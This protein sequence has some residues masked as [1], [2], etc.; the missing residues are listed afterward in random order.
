MRS[1]RLLVLSLVLC[2][3]NAPEPPESTGGTDVPAGPCGRGLIVVGTDNQSTNVSLLGLDGAVLSSS[4]ISSATKVTGLSTQLGNDVVPP[5]TPMTGDSIVL[6]DRYPASVLTW[7]DVKSA[8]VGGQLSIRA[9]SEA[10]PHD[11]LELTSTKAYVTRYERNPLPGAEPFDVGDDVLVID[12]SAPAMTASIALDAARPADST[13]HATPDR[14][15]RAGGD[16]IAVLLAE[17]SSHL[18]SAPTRLVRIDPDSDAITE[19][20]VL[21]GLYQCLALGVAPDGHRLALGCAGRWTGGYDTVA[22]ESGVVVVDTEGELRELQ[23]FPATSL[24]A[25]PGYGISWI[26]DEALAVVTLGSEVS[27]KKDRLIRLELA[28]GGVEEAWSSD[29]FKLPDVRCA[30]A[31]GACFATDEARAVVVRLNI[32]GGNLGSPTPIEVDSA[33][34]LPP[35]WLGQF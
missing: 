31:C 29:P 22:G 1:R 6:L 33:I 24:G 25:S 7:V 10:N 3:C 11:Y 30:P 9:G 32:Q 19:V 21:D 26:S 17:T 5:T 34:G 20:L 16:V 27:G 28:T 8:G 13:F 23:R 12:P 2:A 14:L 18:D 15:V 4:F 35:R